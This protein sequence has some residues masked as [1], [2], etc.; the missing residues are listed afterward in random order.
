MALQRNTSVKFLVF[1]FAVLFGSLRSTQYFHV[2]PLPDARSGD[3]AVFKYHPTAQT[4]IFTRHMEKAAEERFSIASVPPIPFNGIIFLLL[5]I[6]PF[7]LLIKT[8]RSP[9]FVHSLSGIDLCT[10]LCIFRL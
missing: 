3:H 5:G 2:Q 10:R 8:N 6:L 4:L 7:A 9:N 1:L